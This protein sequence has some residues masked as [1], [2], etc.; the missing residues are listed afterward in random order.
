MKF[1]LGISALATAAIAGLAVLAAANEPATVK[2]TVTDVFGHR[3]VVQGDAG[4]TLV[5]IGPK[6]L[7]AVTVKSGDQVTIEGERKPTEVKAERVTIGTA[8]PVDVREKDDD[9]DDD[10]KGQKDEKKDK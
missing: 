1:T 6:G 10:E 7:K 9:D 8:A 4:K 5:D 3:F 2:G